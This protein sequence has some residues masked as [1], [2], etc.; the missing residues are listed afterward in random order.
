MKSKATGPTTVQ[1]RYSSGLSVTLEVLLGRRPNTRIAGPAIAIHCLW[2]EI[3]VSSPELGTVPL[4]R[5]EMLCWPA[6]AIEIASGAGAI[7]VLVQGQPAALRRLGSMWDEP[8]W[9]GDNLVS[10]HQ[11]SP[12]LLRIALVELVRRMRAAEGRLDP[13]SIP[14]FLDGIE[15]YRGGLGRRLASTPGRTLRSRQRGYE[16]LVR[17]RL[18]V[19]SQPRR[20]WTLPEMAAQAKFSVWHF[21]RAFAAVFD[22]TPHEFVQAVRLRRAFRLLAQSHLSI[23]DIAASSGFDNAGNLSRLIKKHHGVTATRLRRHRA[24]DAQL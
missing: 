1:V 11:R 8:D 9:D 17:V 19:L 10:D 7:G 6:G 3:R 13:T 4:V 24:R 5:G 12:R 15:A 18:Q 16:R 20:R 23:S 14:G 2:G 22:E 21:Q